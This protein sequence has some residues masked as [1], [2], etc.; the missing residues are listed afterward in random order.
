MGDFNAKIEKER[1]GD[2]TG[3]YRL[4]ERNERGNLLSQFVEEQE[5]V[6]TNTWFQLAARRLYT[7][8]SPQDT[9]G[10]ITRNQVDIE[11]TLQLKN[12]WKTYIDQLFYGTRPEPPEI[13]DDTGPYILADEVTEAIKLEKKSPGPD[14]INTEF[15]KLL[16]VDSVRWMTSM[17]NRIHIRKHSA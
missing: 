15:L 8:K 16:D 2:T 13:V 7:W 6:I 1:V 12:A 17:F 5:L 10:P 14:N 4:G 9:S 3:P 11:I